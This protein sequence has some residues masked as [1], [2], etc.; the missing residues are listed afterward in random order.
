MK[1]KRIILL[2]TGV[3]GKICH[4]KLD[5][6]I[7]KVLNYLQQE[8]IGLRVAEI[9]DYELRRNFLLESLDKSIGKLN[10]FRKTDR[11]LFFD[12]ETMIIASEIWAEI[13]KQGNPTENKD[14]LDGDVILAAQACQLKEYYEE[15]IILTTNAK[16]IAKFN[17]LGLKTWDWKQA[18]IDSEYQEF[19]FYQAKL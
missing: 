2:D 19:N 1:S 12:T 15:V 13:R 9:S 14:S 18:V 16:D 17:Y 11:L 5:N 6:N 3:L 4:K 8:K 10:K 7:T